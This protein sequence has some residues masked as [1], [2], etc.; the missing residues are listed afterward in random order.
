[1]IE[2]FSVGMSKLSI[3][4]YN[5]SKSDSIQMDVFFFIYVLKKEECIFVFDILVLRVC[6]SQ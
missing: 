1:M 5:L 3:L 6:P 2:Q 4:N